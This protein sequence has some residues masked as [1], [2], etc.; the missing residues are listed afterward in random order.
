M[1]SSDL[2]EKLY[3]FY[4]DRGYYEEAIK[5]YRKYAKVGAVT[6]YEKKSVESELKSKLEQDNYYLFGSKDDDKPSKSKIP[7]YELM[8]RAPG[9][10]DG[11]YC[12]G[13]CKA[14]LPRA[15]LKK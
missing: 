15:F 9:R 8:N 12:R 10:K 14:S 6:A 5:W 4:K 11:R 13:D 2:L 3:N 1:C 7:S